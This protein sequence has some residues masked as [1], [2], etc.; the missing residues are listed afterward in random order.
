MTITRRTFLQHNAL[1]LSAF[2]LSQFSQGQSNAA[3]LNIVLI[4]LDDS[5]WGDFRPFGSPTYP[6]PKVDRLAQEGCAYRNFYV[7]QAICS[8]SRAAL[9]TSCYPGRTGVFGAHGPMAKGL[10]P[11][12]PTMGEALKKTM[13]MSPLFSVSG[14]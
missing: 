14:I 12:F 9:M 10:D 5:G 1:A 11:Q 4:F 2:G 3:N 8:A 6:T 13:D 7:P